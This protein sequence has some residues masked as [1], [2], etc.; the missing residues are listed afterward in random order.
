MHLAL[1]IIPQLHQPRQA[2]PGETS[3]AHAAL[4]S[5]LQELRDF[6]L[7]VFELVEA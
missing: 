3:I 6:L 4:R 2:A 7:D 1:V 5:A